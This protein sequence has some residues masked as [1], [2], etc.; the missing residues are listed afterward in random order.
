[1]GVVREANLG[2]YRKALAVMK[3]LEDLVAELCDRMNSAP[4][5]KL[6]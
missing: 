1:L 5:P 3:C 2:E 6:P 4:T